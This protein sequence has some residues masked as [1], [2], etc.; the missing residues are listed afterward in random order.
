MLELAIAA[1][2]GIAAATVT[3]LPQHTAVRVEARQAG[4]GR[5]IGMSEGQLDVL[6]HAER[7]LGLTEGTVGVRAVRRGATGTGLPTGPG[8]AQALIVEAIEAH[9]VTVGTEGLAVSV[10]AAQD[11]GDGVLVGGISAQIDDWDGAGGVDSFQTGSIA[12]CRIGHQFA[13]GERGQALVQ[14][15]EIRGKDDAF[16]GVGGVDAG[17]SDPVGMQGIVYQQ[18]GIAAIAIDIAGAAGVFYTVL[19]ASAVVDEAGLGVAWRAAAALLGT[20]FRVTG[21]AFLTGLP[22][23]AGTWVFRRRGLVARRRDPATAH[24]TVRRVQHPVGGQGKPIARRGRSVWIVRGQQARLLQEGDEAGTQIAAEGSAQMAEEDAQGGGRRG[25]VRHK[26][27]QAPPARTLRTAQELRHLAPTP[28][29][30]PTQQ[31][32]EKQGH[33]IEG[34]PA[35]PIHLQSQQ[36][37]QFRAQ[38]T[39]I[40]QMQRNVQGA[41]VLQGAPFRQPRPTGIAIPTAGAEVLRQI[42]RCCTRKA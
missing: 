34:R 3:P 39:E 9:R 13:D 11:T 21:T 24:G 29:C 16:I 41:A 4:V 7:A 28:V 36:L 17:V 37:Y 40:D 31:R 2:G 1:F 32:A 33:G 38:R 25:I 19:I 15:G 27:T 6:D 10:V 42:L 20:A 12:Q 26:A 30:F 18:V 5:A 14:V 23:W 22:C 8:G 35:R